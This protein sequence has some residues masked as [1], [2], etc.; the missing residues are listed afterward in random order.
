MQHLLLSS[1]PLLLLRITFLFYRALS[2]FLSSAIGRVFSLLVFSLTSFF[3]LVLY[4][5]KSFRESTLFLP[6][7]VS[8]HGSAELSGQ[9]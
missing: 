8:L 2:F 9:F 3:P 6:F 5:V 1:L 4:L 7:L